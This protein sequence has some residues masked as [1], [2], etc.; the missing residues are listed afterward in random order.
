MRGTARSLRPQFI[1]DTSAAPRGEGVEDEAKPKLELDVGGGIGGS[2]KKSYGSPTSVAFDVGGGGG[3]HGGGIG[4]KDPGRPSA[5]FM[6][7]VY[8]GW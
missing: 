3:I 2:S 6:S 5:V 8:G 7:P 1:G 4:V